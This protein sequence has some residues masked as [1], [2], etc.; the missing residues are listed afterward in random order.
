[1][2]NLQEVLDQKEARFMQLLQDIGALRRALGL[3]E[4]D[5]DPGPY[6]TFSDAVAPANL[7]DVSEAQ[8]PPPDDADMNLLLAEMDLLTEA[9]KAILDDPA[10]SCSSASLP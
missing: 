2:K 9:D 3:L 7:Y 6:D 4:E 8:E 1:M 5:G 10:D